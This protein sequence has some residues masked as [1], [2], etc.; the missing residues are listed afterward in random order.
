MFTSFKQSQSRKLEKR[1]LTRTR[2]ELEECS[3]QAASAVNRLA[4]LP[5]A[6][7]GPLLKV[8]SF[9]DWQHWLDETRKRFAQRSW[10]RPAVGPVLAVGLPYSFCN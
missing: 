1:R 10:P 2:E 5:V 4:S 8:L 7:P 6:G 3:S 9:L